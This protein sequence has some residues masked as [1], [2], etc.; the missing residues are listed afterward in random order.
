MEKTWPSPGGAS[1]PGLY[2]HALRSAATLEEL[3]NIR[4]TNVEVDNYNSEHQP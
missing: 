1:Y 4:I 3:F 2:P